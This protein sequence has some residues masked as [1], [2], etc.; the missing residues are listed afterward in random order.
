MRFKEAL[1][2]RG[3]QRNEKGTLD[4]NK[5]DVRSIT[6]KYYNYGRVERNY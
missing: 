6:G 5:D 1:M 3:Y 2:E 4:S